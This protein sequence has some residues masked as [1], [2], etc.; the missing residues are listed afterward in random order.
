MCVTFLIAISE[1]VPGV[2]DYRARP[3]ITTANTIIIGVQ[4]QKQ[5]LA[6]EQ[7]Q[8]WSFLYNGSGL[9]KY[10][11]RNSLGKYSFFHLSL[12]V[13]ISLHYI[14]TFFFTN[15][16]LGAVSLLLKNLRERV[17]VREICKS[18]SGELKQRFAR[19]HRL[20]KTADCEY[21]KM[22]N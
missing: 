8:G 5:Q 16:K 15:S 7:S 3:F 22:A 11:P 20:Q 2:R 12:S 13:S 10:Y 6:M 14:F 18:A 4:T 17:T 19:S 21:V 1:R 9:R